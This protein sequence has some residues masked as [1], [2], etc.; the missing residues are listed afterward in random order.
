MNRVVPV[1]LLAVVLGGCA[2]VEPGNPPSAPPATTTSAGGQTNDPALQSAAQALEPMLKSKFHGTY[3]GLEVNGPDGVIV[4]YR[5]PD[6]A[7]DRAVH[8][9]APDV[10]VRFKQSVYPLSK[11]ES[12]VERLDADADYWK[13]QGVQLTTWGPAPDGSGVNVTTV[14]GEVDRPKLVERYGD[15]IR[16]TRA[17]YPVPV[18]KS[19]PATPTR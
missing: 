9:A 17:D 16:V 19:I 10:R 5:V 15:I 3:S 6:E 1:V 8:E 7:L 18:P 11:M 12:V 13:S 4:V 2:R 14:A